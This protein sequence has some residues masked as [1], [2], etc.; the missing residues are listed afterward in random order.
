V[1]ENARGTKEPERDL[2][3]EEF[4]ARLATEVAERQ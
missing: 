1:G 4:C 2:A 3:F